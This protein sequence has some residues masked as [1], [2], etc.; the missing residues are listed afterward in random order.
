ME[1]QTLKQIQLSKFKGIK[2]QN[3]FNIL[4]KSKM[5]KEEKIYHL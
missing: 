1:I 4:S 3:I 2:I 5:A